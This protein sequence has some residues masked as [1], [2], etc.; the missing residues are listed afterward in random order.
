MQCEGE[1]TPLPLTRLTNTTSSPI[2]L[3]HYFDSLARQHFCSTNRM[4][5]NQLYY[6]TENKQRN[7]CLCIFLSKRWESRIGRRGAAY[8][9]VCIAFYPSPFPPCPKVN[10]AWNAFEAERKALP[11]GYLPCHSK[12]RCCFSDALFPRVKIRFN[13]Q[14]LLCSPPLRFTVHSRIT[15]KSQDEGTLASLNVKL[16]KSSLLSFRPV[17]TSNSQR[18]ICGYWV[19]YL[20]QVMVEQFMC[21]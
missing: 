21:I 1:R 14:V 5:H 8:E 12:R 11:M 2:S 15:A 7:L 18:R 17:H 19:R 10:M 20:N 13:P 3:L 16:E 6:L 4:K 9:H